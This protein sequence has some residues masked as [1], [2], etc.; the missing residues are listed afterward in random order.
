M[1]HLISGSLI[2]YPEGDNHLLLVPL[3]F[4]G[5]VILIVLAQSFWV[6]AV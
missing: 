6:G 3:L 5:V 1:L 2:F 4:V